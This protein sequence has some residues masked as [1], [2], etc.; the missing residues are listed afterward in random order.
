MQRRRRK[1]VDDDEDCESDYGGEGG[2]GEE[3]ECEYE[4]AY[5]GNDDSD[6]PNQ[7]PLQIV[8]L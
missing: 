3:E 6:N 1:K 7:C 4:G 8:E 2:Y 5:E